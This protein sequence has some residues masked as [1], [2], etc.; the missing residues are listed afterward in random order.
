M[1]EMAEVC[2]RWAFMEERRAVGRGWCVVGVRRM[3]GVVVVVVEWVEREV[4]ELG[5]MFCWLLLLVLFCGGEGWFCWC[6]CRGLWR[7]SWVLN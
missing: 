4:V 6:K 5:G 3:R 7:E 2:R 1:V